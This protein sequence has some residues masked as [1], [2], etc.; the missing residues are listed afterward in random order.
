MKKIIACFSLFMFLF[1]VGING[2]SAKSL[3]DLQNELD[4]LIAKK[5]KA[6]KGAQLTESEIANINNEIISINN[7]I[8]KAQKDVINA[9][10]E[11]EKTKN[12]IAKKEEEIKEILNYLQI[13]NGES[14]YL[15]YVSGSADFTE[16]IYRASVA[17]QLS[18]YNKKMIKDY[19]DL[20]VKLKQ[21]QKDLEQKQVTLAQNRE[22]LNANISTLR[23]QLSS[24]R[25]EGTSVDDDIAD[26]K[27]AIAYYKSIGCKANQ[28]ISTCI[29]T[30]YANGWKYPLMRGMVTSEYTGYA[31]RTDWSGGGHHHG[32]DL[33]GVPEGTNVYAAAPGTVARTV[34]HGSCGGNMVFVNHNVNG[35]KYTTVYMHL[36]SIAGGIQKGKIVYDTTVIGAMGGRSYGY[37]G[38]TGGVHL[39]F[40]M[41]DGW[42]EFSFNPHSF[43]PRN[44]IKFPK[45]Y[46]GYFER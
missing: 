8:A 32:I 2:T 34:Y 30:P 10:K 37:D 21:K 39:H 14:A 42:S 16:F 22:K 29:K 4:S 9:E 23:V 15:E 36:K 27:K 41:A 17:E 6:L 5:E 12:N 33:S 26:M 3:N 7:S 1:F 18:K 11:I 38:C 46:G 25:E 19:N 28:D 24:F 43:N 40:G 13:S 31:K 45:M 35:R 20:I 44:L